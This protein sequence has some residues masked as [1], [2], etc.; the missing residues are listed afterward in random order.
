MIASRRSF[1]GVVLASATAPAIVRA[2]NIMRI[3]AA[4][5]PA[6][7]CYADG[8]ILLR[9]PGQLDQEFRRAVSHYCGIVDGRAH[10]FYFLALPAGMRVAEGQPLAV[11]RS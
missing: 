8:R 6:G 7:Y 1:L 3:V 11:I 9:A 4:P 2:A 5:P 10:G